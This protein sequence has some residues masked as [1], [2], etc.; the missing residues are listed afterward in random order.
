MAE[1]LREKGL[2]RI[3][4]DLGITE[5]DKEFA[6]RICEL[7][8]CSEISSV[9]Q[10]GISRRFYNVYLKEDID[11]EGI[12]CLIKRLGFLP[13]REYG[14]LKSAIRLGFEGSG[15]ESYKIDFYVLPKGL[16]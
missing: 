11:K 10:S 3:L 13:S 8:E 5:A 16:E 15:G 6:G 7:E 4:K 12:L 1:D 14:G 9:T 2:K